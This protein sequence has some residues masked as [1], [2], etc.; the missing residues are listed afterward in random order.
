MSGEFDSKKDSQSKKFK[1]R[2]QIFKKLSFRMLYHSKLSGLHY[3][4]N[5]AIIH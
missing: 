3:F 5:M 4:D 1:Q 2:A